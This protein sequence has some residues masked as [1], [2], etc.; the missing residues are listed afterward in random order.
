MK[1]SPN[2]IDHIFQSHFNNHEVAVIEEDRLWQRI[3]KN[4]HR[5][6]RILFLFLFLFLATSGWFA[7]A[8][9]VNPSTSDSSAIRSK[10]ESALNDEIHVQNLIIN[11]EELLE[12]TT[13]IE[14]ESKSNQISQENS[15]VNNSSKKTASSKVSESPTDHNE[16]NNTIPRFKNTTKNL[17]VTSTE[18][19]AVAATLYQSQAKKVTT[20]SISIP[21]NIAEETSPPVS[22]RTTPEQGTIQVPAHSSV[23]TMHG[24]QMAALAPLQFTLSLPPLLLKN[25]M[26]AKCEIGNKNL[27]PFIDVYGLFA[28]PL[29]TVG[30]SALGSDQLQ[31]LT[32]WND[33]YSPLL[34]FGGGIAIGNEWA[35]GISASVGIEYQRMESQYKTTQTVTEVTT[36]FDP[37]AFFFIDEN[38]EVVWVG[39]S[40][41]SV[42]TYDRSIAH[43][44]TTTLI[45]I[46]LNVSYNLFQSGP[47]KVKA[48]AGA[49]LNLSIQY[50][51]RFLASDQSLQVI[52]DS[53][54][55][56]YVTS[57]L[58]TSIEAGVDFAYL[59]GPKW[60]VYLSPRYRYNRSSYWQQSAI[61]D[62]SR[63]YV[64]FRTGV[65][66]LF[67]Q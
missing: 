60:E 53:N 40:V 15:S 29:E 61:I 67:G 50:R 63:D 55:D 20:S 3:A 4:I 38:D 30:L 42:T 14:A 24:I 19:Q 2:E 46:P 11:A 64:G 25:G 51:G 26:M 35:N 39:D 5:K 48:T 41:T 56:T 32:N 34:S 17:T 28:Q 33:R 62:L 16:N 8:S 7:Y 49:I 52:D 58:G 12:N 44:N 54:Q 27:N 65:R 57:R 13:K 59:I 9:L 45:N 47:W 21:S 31:Y 23:S 36:I 66:Y 1:K 18:K 22:L 43:A 6:S 37:M 10:E